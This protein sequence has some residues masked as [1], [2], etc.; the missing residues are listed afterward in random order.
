MAKKTKFKEENKNNP[1]PNTDIVDISVASAN[2]IES[3]GADIVNNTVAPLGVTGVP[4]SI[5]TEN[6]QFTILKYNILNSDDYV[7]FIEFADK[8]NLFNKCDLSNLNKSDLICLI[9][10][11]IDKLY[12]K[13]NELNKLQNE[14]KIKNQSSFDAPIRYDDLMGNLNTYKTW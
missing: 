6:E 9:G 13:E 14:I 10:F 1:T 4:S 2:T 7:R 3:G 12:K 8:Y 11:V 5:N